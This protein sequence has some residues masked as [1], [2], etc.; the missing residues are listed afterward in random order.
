[1]L[2]K[3]W[4]EIGGKRFPE[5]SWDLDFK[6]N[7]YVLAYEAFQDFKKYFFKTDS[8]PYV[9][10]KGFKF[11]Y[12]IYSVNLMEQPQDISNVKS[13]IIFHVDFNE[14]VKDPTGSEEGT[15]C[16]IVILSNCLL[17]YEA[18]KNKITKVN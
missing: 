3:L 16:S 18:D 11:M 4:M 13:N 7:Y 14:P 10:K 15:I 8:I 6:N 5:E 2:K 12:P 9:D 17:R 1:M